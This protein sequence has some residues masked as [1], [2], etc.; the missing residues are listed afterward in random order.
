MV[1]DELAII[2]RGPYPD[3]LNASF[4]ECHPDRIWILVYSGN[5]FTS[6]CS[7]R[8]CRFIEQFPAFST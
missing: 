2:R 4:V 7:R 5:L 1:Y 6:S 8:Q 3:L